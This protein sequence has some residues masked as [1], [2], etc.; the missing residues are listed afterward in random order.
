MK[1]REGGPGGREGR[2]GGGCG[3]GGCGGST[4]GLS[5]NNKQSISQIRS[6]G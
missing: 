2:G 4:F 3:G 6:E 1:G 5:G